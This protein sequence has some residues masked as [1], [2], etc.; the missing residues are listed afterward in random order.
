MRTV[1]FA[2]ELFR[3]FPVV[4]ALLILARGAAQPPQ[5]PP[6]VV[7]PPLVPP[8]GQTTQPAQPPAAREEPPA[9]QPQEYWVRVVRDRVNLRSR[10]DVSSTPVAQ[11]ERDS[12]LR[13]TA[14]SDGWLRVRPPRGVFCLVAAEYVDQ[15][16]PD[17]GV[18]NISSGTLRVRSGSRVVDVDPLQSE[19]VALLERG[20]TVQ[21]LGREGAWL[22]IAP[23][24][25][26]YVYVASEL[27]E[28][29]PDSQVSFLPS[30]EARVAFAPDR[31]SEEAPAAGVEPA[32]AGPWGQKLAAAEAAIRRE[33]GKPVADR[34]WEPIV[35][36]LR[37]IA[38]QQD[39]P[40]VAARA[41]EWIQQLEQ[42]IA[43]QK[44]LRDGRDV[45]GQ[46]AREQQRRREE[47]ERSRRAGQQPT[48]RPGFDARG[49]LLP[50]FVLEAGEHGL[51]YRLQDP[52]TRKV[53]AYVEFPFESGI[54]VRQCLGKY[55]GVR[56]ESY[57]DAR[58]EVTVIRVN[59]LTVLT[60][61]PEKPVPSPATRPR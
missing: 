27:V 16:T 54:D 35:G 15:Q 12:F 53:T 34:E 25:G 2:S 59:E 20:Q 55:V 26:V 49:Q 23:P 17:R 6:P 51:R 46:P 33:A 31:V 56:G 48:T 9:T 60:T 30:G 22:R 11:V 50:T 21:I 45:P 41:A 39:E 57:V 8:A 5:E 19:A 14:S 1:A 29:V 4:C 24:E 10:P 3:G 13:V 52:I 44:A 61:G 36:E 37:A 43:H 42:R 18:V 32:L 47:L 7:V 28:R 38:G 58:H 40:Q